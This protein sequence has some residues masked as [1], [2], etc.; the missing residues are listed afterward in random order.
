MRLHAYPHPRRRACKTCQRLHT[1]TRTR[2]AQCAH[3]LTTSLQ[4]VSKQ[5]APSASERT[6][7]VL[8]TA[9]HEVVLGSA[10]PTACTSVRTAR[11]QPRHSACKT[12]GCSIASALRTHAAVTHAHPAH[13]HRVARR[14]RH[15][16]TAPAHHLP[17]V[18]ARSFPRTRRLLRV[19]GP[20]LCCTPHYLKRSRHGK[21][22][23]RWRSCRRSC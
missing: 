3:A 10:T 19:S 11:A 4:L 14:H 23:A 7:S 16:R 18:C 13:T 1:C 15:T 5:S 17:P 8:H 9:S 20:H 12:C 6:T 2:H 22:S 21:S